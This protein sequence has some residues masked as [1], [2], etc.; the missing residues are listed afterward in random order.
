MKVRNIH[1]KIAKKFNQRLPSTA[2]D[3]R[4]YEDGSK[5]D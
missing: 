1:A 3:V 5:S 2:L 4:K